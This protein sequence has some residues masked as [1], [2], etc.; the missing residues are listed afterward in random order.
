MAGLEFNHAMVYV[1]ELGRSLDFYRDVLGFQVIETYP[2][3]YARLKSPSG[4]TSIALHVLDEGTRLDTA[5]EGMRLYF[6]IETL[7]AFC[8]VLVAKGVAFKQPPQDMPW[9]WRHAYLHDPDGHEISL[10]WAG[11][12]RFEPT[13]M[14]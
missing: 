11:K 9:G 5:A 3:A 8:A 2:N 6:E 13:K 14:G 4:T 12:K 7:D 10:Y 1:T